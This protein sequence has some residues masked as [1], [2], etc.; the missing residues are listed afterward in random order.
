MIV[1]KR[2]AEAL[3]FRSTSTLR[4]RHRG[5][6][7]RFTKSPA[8]ACQTRV[9]SP[10]FPLLSVTSLCP[11]HPCGTHAHRPA[12][13][14]APTVSVALL[15]GLFPVGSIRALSGPKRASFVEGHLPLATH[16]QKP[17]KERYDP[18]ERE[19]FTHCDR[20]R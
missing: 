18:C 12:G 11:G 13:S 7:R 20:G 10:Y 14:F 16:S 6:G 19:S 3:Q 9:P 2:Q 15:R 4:A 8:T 1:G 17:D 5:R